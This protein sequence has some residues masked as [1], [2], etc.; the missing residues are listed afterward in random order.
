MRGKGKRAEV[1]VMFVKHKMVAKREK[2]N[3]E[4]RIKTAGGGIPEC[5]Q[6]N[7]FLKRG[8]KEIDEIQYKLPQG[9][10]QMFHRGSNQFLMLSNVRPLDS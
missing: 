8:V 6:G 4:N 10:M 3:I 9:M 7:V 1:Q 5:L 2:A